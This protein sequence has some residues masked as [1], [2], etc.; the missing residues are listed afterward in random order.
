MRC[1]LVSV[2]SHTAR[3]AGGGGGAGG[4]PA[5]GGNALTTTSATPTPGAG[6]I[7]DGNAGAPGGAGFGGPGG[8]SQAGGGGGG[9]ATAFDAVYSGGGGSGV[10]TPVG[11]FY[12]WSAHFYYMS[13]LAH[14]MEGTARAEEART[15][16]AVPEEVAGGQAAREAVTWAALASFRQAREQHTTSS[17]DSQTQRLSL[18]PVLEMAR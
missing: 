1:H 15:T 12:P 16:E 3:I 7:V 9:C 18:L 5:F 4:L 8:L 13:R 17:Q 11:C 6:G 2:A 10:R 14:S